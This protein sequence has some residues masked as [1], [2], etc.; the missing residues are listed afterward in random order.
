[1]NRIIRKLKEAG[2]EWL[3]LRDYAIKA[4]ALAYAPYS[5]FRVGCAIRLENGVIIQGA[6]QENASYPLCMCA[7]R[8]ALYNAKMQFPGTAIKKMLIT[9][10]SPP[11]HA[12]VSPCG[13]CRQVIYEMETLQ[14]SPIEI[15]SGSE[16]TGYLF[17]RNAE[18]LLPAPFKPS[19]LKD[20]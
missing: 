12:P 17:F 8:I 14:S 11:G 15:F 9:V 4:C 1:M 20:K 19:G 10:Q 16:E 7:E 5:E 13:A 18:E 2:S 6:N 3:E